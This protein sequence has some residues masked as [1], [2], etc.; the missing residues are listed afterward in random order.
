MYQSYDVIVLVFVGSH[1]KFEKSLPR[2]DSDEIIILID[3]SLITRFLQVQAS[4]FIARKIRTSRNDFV[5]MSAK[6]PSLSSSNN[7]NENI[8]I[9][10][11]AHC[12]VTPYGVY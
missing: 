6:N 11:K 9:D 10:C 3:S 7:R 1:R 5:F 4:G 8:P 12:A 2:D